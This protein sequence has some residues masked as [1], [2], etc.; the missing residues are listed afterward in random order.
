M[1]LAGVALALLG[2]ISTSVGM[3]LQKLAPTL[4]RTRCWY[5]LGA[6]LV[7]L[8]QALDFFALAFT[9]QLVVGALNAFGIGTSVVWTYLFFGVRPTWSQ[10]HGLLVILLAVLVILLSADRSRHTY[11]IAAIIDLLRASSFLL[12]ALGMVAL[13]LVFYWTGRRQ[14]QQ[15]L[16][17]AVPATLHYAPVSP[18][19]PS[20][21]T[22]S[23]S[24]VSLVTISGISF[25][26]VPPPPPSSPQPP[27]SHHRF[28]LSAI[29]AVLGGQ[30]FLCSKILAELVATSWNGNNQLK[31]PFPYL[32]AVLLCL[33]A[34]VQQQFYARMLQECEPR[35]LAVFS[36]IFIVM[37][38]VASFCVFQEYRFIAA[39]QSCLVWIGLTLAILGVLVFQTRP[40][41]SS[42]LTHPPEQAAVSSIDAASEN[43]RETVHRDAMTSAIQHEN[44]QGEEA[45]ATAA[46]VG[47]SASVWHV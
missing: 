24:Q 39:E 20:S 27:G 7:L 17:A 16:A 46:A 41:P 38:V 35:H 47:A 3:N 32:I 8:T 9:S 13:A 4:T 28:R 12:Y 2:T 45:Q 44:K 40:P 23:P 22:H 42:P 5:A 29:T 11:D 18:P 14:H 36:C 15:P 25:A 33:S 1:W 31:H 34:Y 30:T 37:T 26:P 21:L 43:E 6:G 19:S 10:L